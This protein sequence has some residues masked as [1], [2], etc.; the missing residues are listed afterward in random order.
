MLSFI[1]I[2]KNEG[3]RLKL[4]LDS[5]Q[6]V[7]IQ[8]GITDYEVVYVDSRSEDDSISLA[9]S[10][11]K[12]RVFLIT[13]NCNAGVGRNIG[14]KETK[15]DILFFID[16]DMELQPGFLSKV[17]TEDGKLTYPFISGLHLDIVYDAN[18]QLLC[19]KNREHCPND[20]PE[21]FQLVT[22]GLFM[23]EKR[24]W[25]KLGG[26]DT[27]LRAN[28]DHDFGLRMSEMGIKLCRKCQLLVQH[29]TTPY[30]LRS[31]Y[32]T[33]ARFSAVV[34]RKHW[35]NWEY[36]VRLLIPTQYTAIM[37]LCCIV[38]IIIGVCIYPSFWWL[39]LMIGYVLV[40]LRKA[41]RQTEV[42]PIK[43]MW[44]VLKRDIIFLSAIL[45]FWPHPIE[46]KYKAVE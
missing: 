19:T 9:K 20:V 17:I 37:L 22:G 21:Y 25:E 33:S 7:V 46:L 12:T 1:V 41:K 10:Y 30:N 43:M 36:W 3:W 28:E 40:L 23:I 34:F 27:R 11:P 8:D 16:G 39:L 38:G 35:T 29:H 2:G 13:G 45:F 18:G 5:I 6:N 42:S 26:I 14:A 4:C 24:Y 15:G 31:T 32:S 44:L